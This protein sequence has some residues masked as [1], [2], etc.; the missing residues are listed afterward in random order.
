MTD[1]D[2][3]RDASLVEYG[4]LPELTRTLRALGSARRSGGSMQSQFF[5]PLVDARRRAAECTAPADCISAFD[6]GELRRHLHQALE[7]IIT[8][9]PD[10]RSS[11]RRALRA[12]LFVRVRPYSEALSRLAKRAAEAKTAAEETRLDAWR[13]WTTQLAST[14]EAADRSW[15]SLRSVV[16]VLPLKAEP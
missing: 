9:W 4:E 8:H 10:E 13:G 12:E 14:F 3:V 7:R 15:M 2:R 6:A 16:D 11:V 1:D 5:L